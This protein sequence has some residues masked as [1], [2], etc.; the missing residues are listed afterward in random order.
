VLKVRVDNGT[1]NK[2][3]RQK[4]K[5]TVDGFE[6]DEGTKKCLVEYE[7]VFAAFTFDSLFDGL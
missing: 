3:S 6:K 4:S 5:L 7:A 2:H 1:P